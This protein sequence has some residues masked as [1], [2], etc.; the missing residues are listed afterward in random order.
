MVK[1]E[2]ELS[3]LLRRFD[4]LPLPEIVPSL[5]PLPGPLRH[6]YFAVLFGYWSHD[7]DYELHLHRHARGIVDVCHKIELFAVLQVHRPIHYAKTLVW[8]LKLEVSR[9]YCVPTPSVF[10]YYSR[11]IC[12]HPFRQDSV[13]RIG[14]P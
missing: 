8:L 9:F 11:Y 10:Q 14:K 7:C 1:Y 5:V 6:L 2:K 4:G 12:K 3:T 13:W